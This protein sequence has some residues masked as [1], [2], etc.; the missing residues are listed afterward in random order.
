MTKKSNLWMRTK[1]LYLIPAV[2]ISF[3]AIACS[4][5][6]ESDN[7][8]E[9][10]EK[11]EIMPEYPGGMESMMK[12]MKESMKYPEVAEKNGATGKAIISFVVEKDGK[13]TEVKAADFIANGEISDE[14]KNALTTEAERVVA[15]MPDWEP[16]KQKGE[17]VRVKY[18]MPITFCLK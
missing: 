15:S 13:V 12:F 4:D 18:T 10:Y 5:S 17:N 6:S 11:V 2:A 8:N 3:C 14:C 1:V 16:G 9:V 7:T